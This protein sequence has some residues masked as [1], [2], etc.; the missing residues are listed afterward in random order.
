[1]TGNVGAFADSERHLGHILKVESVWI[2]FDGTH[3]GE[4]G[5]GFQLIGVFPDP[6]SAKIAVEFVLLRINASRAS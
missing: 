6:D 2:A 5:Q 1:M 3:L 4:D